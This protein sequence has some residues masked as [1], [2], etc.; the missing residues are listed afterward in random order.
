MTHWIW[1]ENRAG[2]VGLVLGVTENTVET[3]I[4]HSRY[5][6]PFQQLL[7]PNDVIIMT[8]FQK[9]NVFADGNTTKA[10][11]PLLQSLNVL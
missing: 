3:G 9:Q 2:T 5:C 7:C 8:K 6:Y 10:L 4:K 1:A 11:N